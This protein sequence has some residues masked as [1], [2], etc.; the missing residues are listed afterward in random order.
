MRS[1]TL[2]NA[3]FGL[4]L[5][6]SLLGCGGSKNAANKK[7]GTGTGSSGGGSTNS[8]PS[9]A[10]VFSLAWSEY[11]SWS[12]FGVASEKG[13]INGKEGAMGRLEQKWGVD[14]KLELLDYDGCI[15]AYQTKNVD[16]VCVTNMDV[17]NPSL[18]RSSVAVLPTSTS[19]GADACIVV[20]IKDVDDL[21]KHKVY[22]LAESVSQYAFARNLELL[23][24]KESDYQFTQ[25]DPG[26]AAKQM[27]AAVKEVKAIM[28]WNPFV[29][30]VLKKEGTKRL[31]DSTNIP[32]EI[33]DLVVVGEDVL[34]KKGGKEFA[35]AVI[36]TYYEFNKMLE[37]PKQRDKLL[38][39]LGE[40]F[41]SLDLDGMKEAV[42]QTRFYKDADE[43]LNLFTGSGKFTKRP[44]T[45]TMDVVVKWYVDHKILKTAPKIGF[46]GADES[47]G[48]DLRFDSSFI[49]MVKE[50]Q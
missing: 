5:G 27:Q 11:P 50:K 17:L 30:Q 31:F 13:L 6:L 28:V 41:S 26:E 2:L 38:V 43:A 44:F 7:T 12:V 15:N 45:E 37:D 42:D 4:L 21:K 46:G 24:K 9:K 14:I 40:K 25:M 34:K 33:I 8:A 29:L 35:C 48:T 19:Y 36:D 3:S 23:G 20:G 39:A 10:P 49:R 47:P 1:R 16:S 22:G 18:T 32:E